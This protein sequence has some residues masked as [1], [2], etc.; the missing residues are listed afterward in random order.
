[1]DELTS[2][3][4]STQAC[5]GAWRT[6]DFPTPSLYASRA[7]VTRTGVA[8]TLTSPA[9]Y[10]FPHGI[11]TPTAPSDVCNATR[12]THLSRFR[13]AN[14]FSTVVSTRAVAT[15]RVVMD[16]NPYRDG[17]GGA[18]T[19]ATFDCHVVSH[20]RIGLGTTLAQPRWVSPGRTRADAIAFLASDWAWTYQDNDRFTPVASAIPTRPRPVGATWTC[21]T[22][23]DLSAAGT[24]AHACLVAEH[25]RVPASDLTT[26]RAIANRALLSF[27]TYG[28]LYTPAQRTEVRTLRRADP[29]VVPSAPS[30]SFGVT[31]CG[32]SAA[33]GSNGAPVGSAVPACTDARFRAESWRVQH[34]ARLAASHVEPQLWAAQAAPTGTRAELHECL[35]AYAML[36]DVE[37]RGACD[38]R[39]HRTTVDAALG[40]ILRRAMTRFDGEVAV[41]LSGSTVNRTTIVDASRRALRLLDDVL[42]AAGRHDEDRERALLES[43]LGHFFA[44]HEEARGL[45]DYGLTTVP[46]TADSALVT[47]LAGGS[48][49]LEQDLIAAALQ[50]SPERPYDSRPSLS[51]ARLL[52][53]L[54]QG[55]APLGRR[56]ETLADTHDLACSFAACAPGTPTPSARAWGILAALDDTAT[57]PTRMTSLQSVSVTGDWEP[58]FGR[59]RDQRS[60]LV[61]AAREAVGA[62][63]Y[64][65]GDLTRLGPNELGR[66]PASFASTLSLARTRWGSYA[67]RGLFLGTGDVAYTSLDRD[68]RAQVLNLLDD[69]TSRAHASVASLRSQVSDLY[70]AVRNQST[71]EATLEQLALRQDRLV[72]EL[73]DLEGQIQANYAAQ[74]VS[75]DD[76]LAAIEDQLEGLEGVLASS[77]VPVTP[78]GCTAVPGDAAACTLRVDASH[79]RARSGD[80]SA[81]EAGRTLRPDVA[82]RTTSVEAGDHFVVQ[83]S[84]QY[85]PTC[86]LRWYL[87]RGNELVSDGGEHGAAPD[88]FGATGALAGSTGFT[89]VQTAG[90]Y[91][92]ASSELSASL[93]ASLCVSSPDFVNFFSGFKASLCANAS[94]TKASSSGSETRTSASF[95][96]G[97][98]LPNT[99]FANAPVGALLAVTTVRAPGNPLHG[100][101]VDVD[102]V[103]GATVIAPPVAADV[104]LIVNDLGWIDRDF[105]PAD[106]C[107]D[108]T[109]HALTVQV[110]HQRPVGNF[111]RQLLKRFAAA[112]ATIRDARVGVTERGVVLANE[113]SALRNEATITAMSSFGPSDG[114]AIAVSDYPAPLRVLFE[115]VLDRELTWLERSA[116]LGRLYRE[117]DARLGELL[118]VNA[119]IASAEEDGVL[120]GAYP[121]WS[122]RHLHAVAAASDEDHARL[123]RTLSRFVGPLLRTWYPAV[124]TNL[125]T[126]P[127][128]TRLRNIQPNTSYELVSADLRAFATAVSQGITPVRLATEPAHQTAER[129][130]AVS[131]PRPEDRMGPSEQPFLAYDSEAVRVDAARA[132]AVWDALL[133]ERPVTIAL[134]PFDLYGRATT[135]SGASANA[136]PH[137]LTCGLQRPIVRRIGVAL[138]GP[139][140]QTSLAPFEVVATVAPTQPIVG[141][142]G[143][144]SLTFADTLPL[145]GAGAPLP[146]RNLAVPVRR[147]VSNQAIA[148]DA[149]Y[150]ALVPLF[151]TL[152]VEGVS[153]LAPLTLE[154]IARTVSGQDRFAGVHELVL[155]LE[156]E[157]QDVGSTQRVDHPVCSL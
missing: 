93:V 108:D 18:L 37:E 59:L 7:A 153:P 68:K 105:G 29:S 145:E 94:A 34:C 111:A 79:A 20:F 73:E 1:M 50:G 119:Q 28:H 88:L 90:A 117:R 116:H 138:A 26:R 27:E 121:E 112:I 51:G 5:R 25:G 148:N 92:A 65:P 103:D 24:A 95:A 83:A 56:L 106:S 3:D 125:A 137:Q 136:L 128:V 4:T 114:P 131:F 15:A 44:R 11:W 155:V 122:L 71:N 80:Q 63:V 10:Y 78:T 123:A 141:V 21:S 75:V 39:A 89:V 8:W 113:L 143:L 62:S 142:S 129:R 66:L 54:G 43:W 120:L 81:F 139:G 101:I 38:V 124:R 151:P 33:I 31:T 16:R 23:D 49:A 74:G 91:Q 19:A 58:V 32:P 99:P 55:L 42:A 110:R 82:A 127:E 157:V 35:D 77:F 144:S 30:G 6:T 13:S 146:W 85:S 109:S 132:A 100:R 135:G 41:A 53:A 107:G 133:S 70:G 156:L 87:A 46:A 64:T 12:D 52:A 98:R 14:P 61:E 2:R 149:P 69:Q 76:Q 118:L 102:V 60:F 150:G 115:L 45:R 48:F 9:S 84:G 72:A 47:Q 96:R 152:E 40:R 67:A 86:S 140:V 22:C 147:A 36:A 104:H 57:L 130:V 134:S 154:T 126:R 97:L 17:A